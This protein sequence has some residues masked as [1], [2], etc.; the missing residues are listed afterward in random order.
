MEKEFKELKKEESYD[1]FKSLLVAKEINKHGC[2]V[3]LGELKDYYNQRNF[4]LEG[5]VA[6]YSIKDGNLV[7]VHKNPELAKQKGYGKISGMLL[8]SALENGANT[9]DCYGEFLT[10]MYMHYKTQ[11]SPFEVF[12][13]ANF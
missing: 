12:F 9:V 5:G 1:F 11:I 2:F 10:N 4:L 7:G 13:P 6:G 8:L 3:D